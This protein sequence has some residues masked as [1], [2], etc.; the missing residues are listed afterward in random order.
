MHTPSP[1][2]AL[3]GVGSRLMLSLLRSPLARLVHLN[4][5]LLSLTVTGRQTGRRFTLVVQYVE[6]EGSILVLAGHAGQKRW[7]RNLVEPARV[8]YR[9]DGR[10]RVGT[11]RVVREPDAWTAGAVAAYVRRYPATA[12]TRGLSP[13]TQVTPALVPQLTAGAELVRIDPDPAAG[14]AQ[15]SAA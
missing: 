13:Q 3:G 4:A 11:A 1:G 8:E 15:T 9:L 10:Q 7:W 12:R 6:H 14:A 2:R 5:S